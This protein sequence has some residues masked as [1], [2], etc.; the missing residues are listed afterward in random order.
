[1]RWV[2]ASLDCSAVTSGDPTRMFG[3]SGFNLGITYRL[4]PQDTLPLNRAVA[5]LAAGSFEETESTSEEP[6]E[7]VLLGMDGMR[8][9][10]AGWSDLQT[11]TIPQNVN[12]NGDFWE[13][14]ETVAGRV[15]LKARR[16]PCR[17][18]VRVLWFG[19]SL[20]S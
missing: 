18:P 5:H 15:A 14:R 9:V 3:P 11:V 13:D 4:D 20:E 1:M 8:P 16:V 7:V 12:D 2:D 10:M 19:G 6:C 17:C